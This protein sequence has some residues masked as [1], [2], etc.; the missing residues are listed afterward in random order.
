M[1]VEGRGSGVGCWGSRVGVLEGRGV[2][3]QRS[4]ERSSSLQRQLR[5]QHAARPSP[6]PPRHVSRESPSGRRSAGVCTRPRPGI[7]Q[8]IRLH[9]RGTTE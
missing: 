5:A 2:S 8:L 6:A 1:R 9:H 7:P 4:R 3:P